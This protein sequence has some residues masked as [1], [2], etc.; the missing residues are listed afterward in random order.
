MKKIILTFVI[1]IYLVGSNSLADIIKQ[2]KISG[3]KNIS[4]ETIEVFADIK[5]NDEINEKLLNEIIKKL[6]S[7]SYFSDVSVNFDNKIL[8]ISVK[9]NPIINTIT[10]KGLK[11]NKYVEQIK[12]NL[13]LKERT[14]FIENK[15]L[16]DINI[17]KS[18][19]RNVGYY[20]I[21]V[22]S[23]KKEND[24]NTIDLIY[25]IDLGEKA[26]IKKI[27]FSGNKFFKDR[28]LKNIIVSEESK[29]WKFISSKKYL[30]E[31]TV[32]LDRRLLLNYFRNKGFYNAV[33]LSSNATFGDDNYFLLT[34][35]I[36]SGKRYKIRK[37]FIDATGEIKQEYFSKLNKKIKKLENEYYSFT[38]VKKVAD[39][40]EKLKIKNELQFI[41]AQI[42]DTIN[43]DDTINIKIKIFET[44]KEYV[45]RINIFGNSITDDHV[46]RFQIISDEGEPFNNTLLARSINNIRGLRIF[47]NVS[48]SVEPGSSNSQK[49]I[50]INVEEKATGEISAG[51]GVGT[52]GSTIAFGIIE[53]NYMGKGIKLDANLAISE[54]SIKGL[55]AVNNPNFRLSGNSLNTRI[56]SS[57]TNRLA[58]QGYKTTKTGFSFGTYFEQWDDI[59]LAPSISTYYE[60]LSTTTTAS[61][62]LIK[63]DGTYFYTNVSYAIIND[64]RDQSFQPTEGYRIAFSQKLPI[65]SD[66][67]SI[68]NGLDIAKYF[69]PMDHV[70]AS[71]RLFSRAINGISEDVRVSERLSVPSK[72]LRG[73]ERG[74]IG[75][76]DSGEH[77][78]GNLATAFGV[79]TQFTNLFPNFTNT[80]FGLF[81]DTANVWGVDFRDSYDDSN[82]IRSSYGMSIDWLTPVGPLSFSLSQAL[83]KMDTDL[84]ESVRFNLGTT[85]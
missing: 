84:E 18:S 12:E 13:S 85:F 39:S 46:I 21:E 71:L 74:R 35:N 26:L 31:Q 48:Y 7:T 32:E 30:N 49:I 79:N 78:G 57:T 36:E 4:K 77:I 43:D 42:T 19:F 66:A 6:Y 82:K 33:V 5:L 55:F 40:I 28:K 10:I 17:I 59:Y 75:P 37:I 56:E 50:N 65:Y 67:P 22:K 83:T 64:K 72:Y 80:N 61:S 8:F 44:K 70:T 25:E 38:K 69:T 2:I 73:F 16:T 52:S 60:N 54:E 29:P 23:F 76:V 9:E 51:A 27:V 3:N 14:S 1:L 45:E 24:N 62:A 11:A 41:E 20:F 63:Q 15:Y 34:Y 53:N 58:D 47:E 81:F 68:R